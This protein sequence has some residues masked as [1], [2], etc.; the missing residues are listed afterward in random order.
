MNVPATLT[1]V[2][3]ALILLLPGSVYQVARSRF[4][5]PTPD[6]ASATNRVLRALGFSAGL[7]ALYL[8]LFG[9]K[10]TQLFI[11]RSGKLS[12]PAAIAHSRV[13]GIWAFVLI[14]VVPTAAALLELGLVLLVPYLRSKPKG[15]WIP[16]L[17][18]D[19]TPRAWDFTFRNA[20]DCFVRL[21]MP[22]GRYLG[23]QFSPASFASGFPEPREIYIHKA[24]KMGTDGE[25]V[26]EQA[27]TLGIYV[28]C[29]DVRAVELLAIQTTPTPASPSPPVG[30]APAGA[31]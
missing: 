27:G 10:L 30:P 18:Y 2:L 6:D 14:I 16:R 13:L 4:R 22:D 25:F 19:A 29:D 11:D 26:T 17:S 3:I 24:W 23:G 28:R 5:G 9:A 12:P 1:Q 20:E 15:S 7:D 31:N 8:I 21:L